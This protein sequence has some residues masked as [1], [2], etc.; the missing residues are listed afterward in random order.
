MQSVSQFWEC[1]SLPCLD[2]PW[3]KALVI[4]RRT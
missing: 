1:R 2:M 4:P 3:L